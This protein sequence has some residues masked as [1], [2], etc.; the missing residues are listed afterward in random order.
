MKLPGLTTRGLA[1]LAAGVTAALLAMVLGYP[2]ITRIGVLLAVLPLLAVLSGRRRT[3]HV[4]VRRAVA[5]D[6]L[7]PGTDGVVRL[8]VR[9]VG[10][11]P[12]LPF[13]AEDLVDPAL[14]EPGRFV[15]P[16]LAPGEWYSV[17]YPLR[18]ALR[19]AYGLGP[20][21]LRLQ[22]P[23]GLAGASVRQGDEA[24]VLVL[25]EV[26]ELGRTRMRREGD[27]GDW[28]VP[29]SIAPQGEDDLSTRHYR[30]G[31]D[32]RRVHWPATAH[33]GQLMVR[34]EERP[35]RRRVALVLDSRARAHWGTADGSFEWAVSA[36]ASVAV[37]LGG[38]GWSLSLVTAE[39]V[40]DGT[41][42]KVL[43][44]D[45]VLNELARATISWGD[46]DPVLRA[47]RELPAGAVVAAVT[48]HD[49]QALGRLAPARPPGA[50]GVLLLLRAE[51]FAE[52]VREGRDGRSAPD[53]SGR[54]GRFGDPSD[55]D[56]DARAEHHARLARV[57]G[58]RTAVVRAGDPVK[59]SWQRATAVDRSPT[60]ARVRVS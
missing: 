60:S 28:P 45:A 31:D 21:A 8:T 52:D 59:S 14:G 19:G 56:A 47:A 50:V 23:F 40:R 7:R 9:N 33:R 4:E 11:R 34:Q 3:P 29:H 6:R 39:T 12:T 18:P 44:A 46:F 53:G 26:H 2:D 55:D 54:R 42:A 20:L 13:L 48:D 58:W 10:R 32:L 27:A 25:P 5:P 30:Y 41:A 24:E 57:A 49:E 17:T 43:T 16:R 51:T 38:Q 35:A 37:H 36:L 22:D 15:L 1:F